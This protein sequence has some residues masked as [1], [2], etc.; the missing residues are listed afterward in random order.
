MDKKLPYKKLLFKNKLKIILYPMNSVKSVFVLAYLRSGGVYEKGNQKGISH[1]IE[2]LCFLGTEKYSSS[3]KI[4][5]ISHNLGASLNGRTERFKTQYWIN[6]PYINLKKGI[7]LLYQIIFK[8]LLLEENIQ[9]EKGVVLSEFYDFWYNPD[10]KFGYEIWKRRFENKNHPYNYPVLGNP[11]TI[12]NFKKEMVISWRK[13]YYNPKNLILTIAGNI[14]P[15]ETIKILEENFGEEKEGEKVREPIFKKINYSN[16]CLYHQEDPRPQIKFALTFPAFGW[17]KISRKMRIATN[18]LN[19]ILGGGVISRLFQR[20]REKEKIVYRIESDF[21]LYPWMGN[22]E[23]WG[24]VSED[25][26][27]LAMRIIKEEIEKILKKGI[28]EEEIK[29]VKNFLSASNLMHF[30]SPLNIAYFLASQEFNDKE[31][32]LPERYIAEVKK[33]KK[34]DLLDLAKKIFNYSKINIGLLG[35]INS[36]TLKEVKKIFK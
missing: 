28:K 9:K 32:W 1:F 16:F 21:V 11:Q 8:P 3:F 30:D 7:N 12:S 13:K 14:N 4:S 25:K 27:V 23:I 18:L 2:H 22:L 34:E 36:Q 29:I 10:Q 20:L 15:K 6:L 35:K 19:Y 31:I 24:S 17:K 26:L 33:I 5:K